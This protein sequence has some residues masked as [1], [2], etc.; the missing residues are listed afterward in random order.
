MI[1]TANRNLLWASILADELVRCGVR[2]AVISPGSRS[3][4]LA[5]AFSEQPEIKVH[6]VLDERAAAFFV[7]GIG[8]ASGM[9]AVAVCTSGTAA[10]NYFPAIIEASEARVPLI[11]MTADRPHE[12]RDSGTNQTIDQ[13]KLYGNYVR[14]FVDV[15]PPHANHPQNT[16]TPLE[17][18]RNST[19]RHGHLP[20]GACA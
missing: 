1:N 18:K 7:L 2:H 9:P 10:A 15:A 13:V 14:W 12:L 8:K 3:T 6:S 11:V 19:K 17:R 4:P 5:V 20:V 16:H